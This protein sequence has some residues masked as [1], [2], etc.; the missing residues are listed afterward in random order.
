MLK[1]TR[2]D[3][4]EGNCELNVNYWYL[5]KLFTLRKA[6]IGL[7]FFCVLKDIRGNFKILDKAGIELHFKVT[8]KIDLVTFTG[9]HYVFHM[10]TGVTRL[11]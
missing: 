7:F 2:R 3:Y 11:I 5:V 9:I 10:V 1:E 4:G 8:I 6:W